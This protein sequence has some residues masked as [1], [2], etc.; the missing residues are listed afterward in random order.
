MSKTDMLHIR[1]TKEEKKLLEE[2]TKSWNFRSISEFLRFVGL[3]CKNIKMEITDE[4]K[5]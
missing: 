5:D 3:N 4:R 1:I 2:K